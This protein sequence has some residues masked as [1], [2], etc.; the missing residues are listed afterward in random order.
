MNEDVFSMIYTGDYQQRWRWP[1]ITDMI[2]NDD[3][4]RTS[5][6][7]AGLS[8]QTLSLIF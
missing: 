8:V 7:W 1:L 4:P 5:Y 2:N 6:T 3:S